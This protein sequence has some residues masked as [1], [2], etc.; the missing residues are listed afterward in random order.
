ML[1]AAEHG[2][3]VEQLEPRRLAR[4]AFDALRVG[5]TAAEHL[6]AAAKPE[7]VPALG[8]MRQEI[9]VPALLPQKGEIGEGCLGARQDHQGGV[10]RQRLPRPDQH[11]LD[12]GFGAQRI[13]I[14]EI[15]D[16]WQQRRGDP[17]TRR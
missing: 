10:K 3:D 17:H 7:D 1:F 2:V 14:V 9:D 5:D 15:G 11:Q 6:E 4:L 16:V 13:E 8:I 12:T